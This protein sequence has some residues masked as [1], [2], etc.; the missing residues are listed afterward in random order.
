MRF[1]PF[2][3]MLLAILGWAAIGA[4]MYVVSIRSTLWPTWAL[5]GA[6]F[7]LGFYSFAK[8]RPLGAFRGIA[9][10]LGIAF[11]AL[12]AL[13]YFTG[14]TTP[15]EAGRIAAG[16]TLPPIALKTAEGQDFEL[17]NGK[18]ALIVLFR[19]FW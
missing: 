7:A 12:F 5:C 3:S 17:P 18:P 1:L 16:D 14:L 9:A 6:A 13:N 19:G 11:S 15:R 10:T 8:V 2:A 4:S